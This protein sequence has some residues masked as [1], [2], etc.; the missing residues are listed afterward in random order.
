MSRSAASERAWRRTHHFEFPRLHLSQ[1][2]ARHEVRGEGFMMGVKLHDPRHPWLSFE[3][4]GIPELSHQSVMSPLLCRRLYA[5]GFFCFTCGHD[6]SI[7]RLQPR[8][9]IPEE[10]LDAFV[11]ACKEELAALADL[12]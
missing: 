10:R 7:F 1:A 9:D 6:W 12:V 5:R 4:F 11:V 8:F 3:H 2:V